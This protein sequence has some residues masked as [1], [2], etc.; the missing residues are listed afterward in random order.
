MNTRWRPFSTAL[1]F[2]SRSAFSGP[3]IGALI[4]AAGGG[5]Y[6]A[7][8][9]I[10]PTSIAVVLS[11]LATELLSGGFRLPA[12]GTGLLAYVFAILMK[13]NT[14]MALSAANLPFPLPA[15]IALGLIMIAGNAVSR[16]LTVSLITSSSKITSWATRPTQEFVPTG[17]AVAAL[18]IGLAPAAMI[19]I[20]GLVGLAAAVISRIAFAAYINKSTELTA[21]EE[22]SSSQQ[23]MEICFYLGALAA[24]P[25]V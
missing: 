1:R 25:Y 14:L 6:W 10:W 20:A 22:R 19:G 2:C 15:N 8:A 3:L 5:I 4:G 12:A 16:A 11:M 7:G 18:A 13:Y 24:W 17:E 21:A 23:L 9:Q